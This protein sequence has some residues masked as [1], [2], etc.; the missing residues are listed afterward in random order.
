[1]INTK[2]VAILSKRD[3]VP[4]NEVW[5]LPK[6]LTISKGQEFTGLMLM[7]WPRLQRFVDQNR[8]R[9]E[10]ATNRDVAIYVGGDAVIP[11]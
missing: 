11:E 8:E 10:Y 4:P 2:Q 7:Q 3:V 1:L 6:Y 5:E 9:F